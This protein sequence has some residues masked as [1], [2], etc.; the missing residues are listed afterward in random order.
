MEDKHEFKLPFTEAEKE[1]ILRK[2][3]MNIFLAKKIISSHDQEFKFISPFKTEHLIRGKTQKEKKDNSIFE[4]IRDVS[5]Y[6]FQ[7]KFNKM[8]PNMTNKLN[9]TSFNQEGM[10]KLDIQKISKGSFKYLIR[11][12]SLDMFEEHVKRLEKAK[13]LFSEEDQIQAQGK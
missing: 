11:T 2:L 4:N 9:K 1:K 13:S 10:S 6:T 8:T 3:G 5:K 12:Y 7:Y